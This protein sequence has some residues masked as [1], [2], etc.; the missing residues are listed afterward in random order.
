M[1]FLIGAEW[2]LYSNLECTYLPYVFFA[3]LHVSLIYLGDK[4][5]CSS[6]NRSIITESILASYKVEITLV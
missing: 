6:A 2:P 4:A 1:E 5:N 3:V